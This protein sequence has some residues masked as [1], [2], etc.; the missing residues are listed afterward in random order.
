MK[1]I[2]SHTFVV[3]AY[4]ECKYLEDCV[5]SLINQTIRSKIIMVTSTDNVFIRDICS[6]YKIKLYVREGQSDIQDDWNFGYNK[7]RSDLVTI[8]HQDDVYD[9]D[10]LKYVMEYYNKYRDSLYVCTDYYILKENK[11]Y[12]D[13]NCRIKS[14]LKFPLRF[15]LLNKIKFFKVASLAFGNSINCPSVTYNS[16]LIGKKNI[17]TSELK[18]SLDWDTFLKFA[19]CKGRLGYVPRKLISFR[20][21]NGAT[22]ASFIRDNKRYREDVIMFSK[23]WPKF[24]V[25][26]IMLFYTKA[27]MV[28]GD[29]LDE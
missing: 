2:F 16:L 9:R 21:H 22:T 24:V 11:N 19:R 6:K 5:K 10:Y 27:S 23:I 20:I 25:K 13:L 3:C 7:A 15:S 14:F 17:F 29:V 28:Y 18:F 4:K 26:I 12:C 8:V 1:K